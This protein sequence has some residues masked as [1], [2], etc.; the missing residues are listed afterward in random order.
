MYCGRTHTCV[1]CVWVC[2]CGCVCM[3]VCDNQVRQTI[4]LLAISVCNQRPLLDANGVMWCD[5]CV[6]TC[7]VLYDHLEVIL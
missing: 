6:C 7:D 1:G 2:V 5:V 3:G 4:Q